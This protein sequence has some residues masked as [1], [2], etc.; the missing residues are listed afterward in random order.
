MQFTERIN[1]DLKKAM[2]EKAKDKLEAIRAIKSAFL[3]ARADKGAG[4]ELTD[5]EE[6]RIMQKLVKQR[7]DS[8]AIYKEQNRKD[9]YDKEIM[10]ATVIESYLPVQMNESDIRIIVGRIINET[11]ASGMKDMGKVMAAANK[12]LA[13]KA[14]GRVISG[15]VKEMLGT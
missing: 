8:A 10:E 15:I 4:S 12:E 2:L 5:A 13:G 7:K 3:L 11:G 9:L 6:I 1:N 14:E